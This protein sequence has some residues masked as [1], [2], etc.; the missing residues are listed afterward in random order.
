MEQSIGVICEI[1]IRNVI[2]VRK[3][4]STDAAK[5][6]GRSRRSTLS[7]GLKNEMNQK[8]APAP[9]ERSVKSASGEIVSLDVKSLQTIILSPKIRY[10]VKHAICPKIESL[11]FIIANCLAKITLFA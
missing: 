11:S 7:F 3:K 9:N 1:A 10:A 2:C 5:I 8:S 6:F 4:P